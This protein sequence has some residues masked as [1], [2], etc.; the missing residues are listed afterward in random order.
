MSQ[1]S[2][3]L[4]NEL[5]DTGWIPSLRARACAWVRR[6]WPLLL[7]AAALYALAYFPT[8]WMIV[9]PGEALPLA[10][11]VDIIRPDEPGDRGSVPGPAG[12][13][14]AFSTPSPMGEVLLLTVSAERA[15]PYQLAAWRAGWLR[16]AALLPEW[17][18][19]PQGMSDEDYV[20]YGRD[21]M[22]ES[23]GL[24]AVLALREAGFQA[25]AS[26]AGVRVI[27]VT[28]GSAEQ[29]GLEAGDIV[30]GLAGTPVA[31]SGDLAPLLREQAAG[32]VVPLAVV[33]RGAEVQVTTRLLEA[34]AGAEESMIGAMLLTVSPGFRLPFPV[35]VDTGEIAGP[36]GGLAM[37]LAIYQQ[38]GTEDIL[39]GRTVAASG[40]IR[41]DGSVGPVGGVGL[42]AVAAARAGA[43][44]LLVPPANA[45]EARLAG[46][47]ITV[48]EV[49][50]YADALARLR[51]SMGE[52]GK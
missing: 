22:R 37:A 50:S 3:E 13:A 31:L 11:R 15:N 24:A 51:S 4:M 18:M 32:D 9:R 16:E 8:G 23:A 36:S 19:I 46:T 45:A 29:G 48:I 41:A 30:T 14:T 49:R 2:L 39:A 33:R 1:R 52:H 5:R 38:L 43:T 26:G 25:S 6:R 44:L 27:A 21:Q 7:A 28:E 40:Y 10:A 42:K 34:T 12:A 20:A 47:G 35:A 17:A